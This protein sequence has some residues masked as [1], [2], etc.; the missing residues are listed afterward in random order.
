MT[1]GKVTFS[2]KNLLKDNPRN[3]ERVAAGARRI[4]AVVAGLSIIQGSDMLALWVVIGG[5]VLDEVKNFFGTIAT[6]QEQVTVKFP[7]SVADDV[8][9]ETGPTRKVNE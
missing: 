4:V 9:I 7:A 6:E 3:I 1:M 8:Q 2:T 5:A